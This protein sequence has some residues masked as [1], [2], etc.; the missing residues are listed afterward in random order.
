MDARDQAEPDKNQLLR[1]LRVICCR[2]AP[3]SQSRD[4]LNRKD[5]AQRY[6]CAIC[7]VA[8]DNSHAPAAA[9]EMSARPPSSLIILHTGAHIPAGTP[10]RRMHARHASHL[11]KP[12]PGRRPWHRA[13]LW[14]DAERERR[15]HGARPPDVEAVA[16]RAREEE[17]AVQRRVE[18][19]PLPRELVERVC[20]EQREAGVLLP[21]ARLAP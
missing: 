20:H 6:T 8:A 3:V 19:P 7:R 16:L 4:T 15:R 14:E 10:P 18:R 13:D 21:R 17:D 12:F 1:R 5:V 2:V 11:C 9:A